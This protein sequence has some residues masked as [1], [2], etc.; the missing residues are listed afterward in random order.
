MSQ[1]QTERV[2]VI[3]T[4]KFHELGYFQGFST[5]VGTYLPELF[6]ARHTSYR[7][8]DEMEENPAF[9][10][11]IPYCLFEYHDPVQGLMLFQ[12]TRGNGQGEQRLHAKRS[13]GIGGHISTEDEDSAAEGGS[14][15]AGMQR[16]LSEEVSIETEYQQRLVGILNDD[17]T[18]VG[19]V[20]LG[21]VHLFTVDSPNVAPRELDIADARFVPVGEIAANVA[22]FE[23]WSQICLRAL[24]PHAS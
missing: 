3:P 5:E 15:E 7:P 18:E 10:Q 20:H 1:V 23:T 9:K 19:R 22:Q 6:D 17:E 16:E 21:V 13:L 24:F 2:L 12:Y 11:L 8:R 14:Y 4:S